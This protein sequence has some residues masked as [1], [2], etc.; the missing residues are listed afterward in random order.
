MAIPPIETHF[1]GQQAV[2]INYTNTSSSSFSPAF[3]YLSVQNTLG[4]TVGVFYATANINAGNVAP[5]YLVIFGVPT[6]HYTG[7]IFATT[8]TGIPI[9]GASTIAMTL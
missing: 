6:G 1:Q 8:P 7:V 5:V 3:V 4:Q 2:N 9:S